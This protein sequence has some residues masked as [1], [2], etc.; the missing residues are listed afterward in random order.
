MLCGTSGVG[1]CVV[2]YTRCRC[3]CSMVHHVWLYVYDVHC[4]YVYMIE[5]KRR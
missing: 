5:E 1:L 4:M 2:L 3:M